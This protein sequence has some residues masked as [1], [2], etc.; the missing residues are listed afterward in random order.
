MPAPV[1]AP[2]ARGP[3][4]RPPA[5]GWG[6]AARKARASMACAV[7]IG[8]CRT[9]FRVI[10]AERGRIGVRRA[11][12]GASSVNPP[13][14]RPSVSGASSHRRVAHIEQA[15]NCFIQWMHQ[16]QQNSILNSSPP[17][18]SDTKSRKPAWTARLWNSVPCS[19]VAA[20]RPPRQKCPP[21]SAP[22][23]HVVEWHSHRKNGGQRSRER[24]PPRRKRRSLNGGS[25]KKGWQGSSLPRRSAG[26]YREQLRSHKEQRRKRSHP[27]GRRACKEG[28]TG[29][30]GEEAS[31][32]QEST[33][34]R[35][36][37]PPADTPRSFSA[38]GFAFLDRKSTRL[39]SSH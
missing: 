23:P 24:Y 7:S 34:S 5:C 26:G 2:A 3:S 30:D 14:Q 39:N 33:G 1:P 6:C 16:C 15:V 11:A 13:E 29:K 36:G 12:T 22:L 9:I 27:S 8:G 37:Y 25:A 10:Q 38:W 19:P 21:A 20:V 17:P 35:P 4:P 31:V 18:S 28:S 32:G